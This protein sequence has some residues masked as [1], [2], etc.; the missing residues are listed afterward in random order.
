MRDPW[1]DTIIIIGTILGV[2]VLAYVFITDEMGG[3]DGG[4]Y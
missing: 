3:P 4:G 1:T 2:I